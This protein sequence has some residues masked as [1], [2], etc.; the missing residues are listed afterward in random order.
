MAAAR[1]AITGRVVNSDY[2]YGSAIRYR[3]IKTGNNGYPCRTGYDL[4]TGRGSWTG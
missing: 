1:A 4:V 2:V 3:D